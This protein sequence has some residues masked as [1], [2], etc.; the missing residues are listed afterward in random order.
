MQAVEAMT[1]LLAI[2]DRFEGTMAD[3]Q[4]E[5]EVEQYEQG[6]IAVAIVQAMLNT[7]LPV[8]QYRMFV[9]IDEVQP[10]RKAYHNTIAAYKE[11][12]IC[13]PSMDGIISGLTGFSWVNHKVRMSLFEQKATGADMLFGFDGTTGSQQYRDFIKQL[14][15]VA[16]ATNETVQ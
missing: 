16:A 12:T 3:A 7:A 9:E 11:H 13:S 6:K 8:A 15:I 5:A 4:S 10:K 2:A 1:R 14:R